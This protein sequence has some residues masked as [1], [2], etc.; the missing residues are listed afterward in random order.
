VFILK[1]RLIHDSIK[2]INLRQPLDIKS[3][4]AKLFH[5]RIE[6]GCRQVIIPRLLVDIA[7][8]LVAIHRHLVKN[9]RRSVEN[10]RH[11]VMIARRSV[12]IARHP[13]AIARHSVIIARH[14]VAIARHSVMIARYPVAVARHSVAIARPHNLITNKFNN[15][16]LKRLISVRCRR[17]ITHLKL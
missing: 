3:K 17:I 12:M 7:R 9:A 4:P 15:I 6:A 1:I 8:H 5:H 11:S 10:H 13:V 16:F 2:L 14:L